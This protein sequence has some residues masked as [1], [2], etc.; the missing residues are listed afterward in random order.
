MKSSHAI[1]EYVDAGDTKLKTS[2]PLLDAT[3]INDRLDED[4]IEST[5]KTKH[6]QNDINISRIQ[7]HDERVKDE[8]VD[9]SKCE[10]DTA[11][12]AS[13]DSHV[14]EHAPVTDIKTSESLGDN[15]EHSCEA[16]IQT[17]D[18]TVKDEVMDK[19]KCETDTTTC[20]SDDS[21]VMEH[22]PVTDNKTSESLGDNQE[23]SCEAR[24][25]THDETVKDEVVDKSKCETDTATCASDDSH[26][27]EHAPVTDNKTSESLGD[28]QE[29]SCEARIQTHDERVK[30][31]VVDK[32]KCETDTATCASDDSHVMEHAP[33]T[34][35]NT[36]ESLGHNQ[37]HSCE[38]REHGDDIAG[39]VTVIDSEIKDQCCTSVEDE[40]IHE[41]EQLLAK[42][43]TEALEELRSIASK[44]HVPE[45]RHIVIEEEANE[46]SKQ[47]PVNQLMT[48]DTG[49]AGKHRLRSQHAAVVETTEQGQNVR[50]QQG[51]EAVTCVSPMS[52][53]L[54]STVITPLTEEQLATIYYNPE[55]RHNEEFI[56]A[57][58]EVCTHCI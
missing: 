15:Q 7:T 58:L 38:A 35:N 10:T 16:R 26:V 45:T 30:D 54:S 14:M 6:E 17:H 20:A 46:T 48:D 18:E 56:E 53:A 27:M 5:S 57:F 52:P 21:H 47:H 40:H 28:N 12:C 2:S 1:E 50:S 25:Q 51:I 11:T 23:H 55:L 19:S 41:Y 44:E 24:I 49:T 42:Y 29:H 32:S 4:V 37:E 43:P 34:D 3:S 33:V 8:V 31:E 13:D 39:E 36:S 9:K 22:A